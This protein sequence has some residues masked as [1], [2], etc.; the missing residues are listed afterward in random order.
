M[1][2]ISQNFLMIYR[3]KIFQSTMNH[4]IFDKLNPHVEN[5]IGL[6]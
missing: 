2:E 4:E 1:I 5:I 3:C 6:Q